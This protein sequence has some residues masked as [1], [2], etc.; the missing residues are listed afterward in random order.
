MGF[1]ELHDHAGLQEHGIAHV[2][3]HHG[4]IY[5]ALLRLAEAIGARHLNYP[6][7]LGPGPIA[8]P[9]DEISSDIDRVAGFRVTFPNPFPGEIGLFTSRGVASFRSVQSLYQAYRIQELVGSDA[10][11]IEIGGG[12]GRTA[13]YARQFGIRDY[14]II[15]LPITNVAQA[16][17]LGRTLGQDMVSLF[18]ENQHGI[19]ILPLTEFLDATDRYD[20]VVNVDSLTEMS[21]DTA[22]AYCKAI[23]SRANKFLSINHEFNPF[24][25][26]EICATL[27]THSSTRTPYWLRCGYVDE[28]FCLVR[29]THRRMYPQPDDVSLMR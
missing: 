2:I 14:T 17:F 24:T 15:D 7:I 1:D 19:R 8:P 18:G 9:V 26:R 29:G 25:V 23:R 3:S 28:V 5:D 13:F 10:R 12:L 16:Y 22:L 6:E 4:W 21:R 27:E 20:L 11:V